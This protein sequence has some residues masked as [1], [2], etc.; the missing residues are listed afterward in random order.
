MR[1]SA[2]RSV[3][4][5]STTQQHMS[6]I[7]EEETMLLRR[8]FFD[9]QN[10]V[11]LGRQ[12]QGYHQASVDWL[13]QNGVPFRSKPPHHLLLG[14]QIAHTLLPDLVAWDAI[15]VEIKAVPRK[16]GTTEFVQLF[17][18]LKCRRDQLGLL[19]NM[20]LDRVHVERII[21]EQP[22]YQRQE[23]WQYWTGHITGREREV[24]AEVRAALQAIYD[25][26]QTGY[27]DEV[28]RKLIAFELQRRRL[29]HVV[30]PISKAFFRGHEVDES[31]LDCFLIE[32]CVVLVYT[33]LFDRNEFN[34]S[35]GL[36]YMKAL[37]VAWGIAANFGKRVAE[38]TGL[39]VEV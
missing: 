9:V 15:T 32:G 5:P 35:R 2:L 4:I 39:R 31:P 36:S 19:V 14:G 7:Y 17:D 25:D 34:I 18:Y 29:A 20:G 38:F 27:G 28:T 13:A 37:R 11:G 12:E 24:G 23:H 10:E 8:C 16:L 6:L 26:H 30:A 33:A 3:G 1:G 22:E 21:Y